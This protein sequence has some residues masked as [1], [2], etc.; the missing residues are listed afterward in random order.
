MLSGRAAGVKLLPTQTY[1]WAAISAT[2]R[3]LASVSPKQKGGRYVCRQQ[4]KSEGKS[5][6]DNRDFERSEDKWNRRS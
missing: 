1:K 3:S 4:E 2:D 6:T 5:T